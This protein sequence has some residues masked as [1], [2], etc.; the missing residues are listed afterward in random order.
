MQ[1]N[2]QV[3]A[4][5]TQPLNTPAAPLAPTAPI[6]LDPILLGQIAGGVS[7]PGRLW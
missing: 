1:V 3:A 6:P 2:I 5:A 4:T 7:A